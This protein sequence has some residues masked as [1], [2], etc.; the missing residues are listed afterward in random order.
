L[1]DWTCTS[2]QGG[3]GKGTAIY[4][5][6]GRFR[7]GSDTNDWTLIL[8]I[9]SRLD[10]PDDTGHYRYW[11]REAS[12]FESGLLE[13]LSGPLT[14]PRHF[15]TTRVSDDE[16]WIW[17]EMIE[18]DSPHWPLE[19]YSPVAR[20]LGRFN[21]AYLTGE[22]PPEAPWLSTGWLRGMVETGMGGLDVL[23]DAIE[24]PMVR[25]AYPRDVF[26]GLERLWEERDLFLD[27]ID[28]LPQTFCHRDAN[29]RN[30]FYND[31]EKGSSRT[32]A[33]D[34]A[35]TGTGAIGEEIVGLAGSSIMFGAVGPEKFEELDHLVFENYVAGLRDVGWEGD[36]SVP[37]LGY[38]A[39]CP[40]HYNFKAVGA[41]VNF[42]LNEEGHESSLKGLERMTGRPLSILQICD[43]FSVATR[44]TLTLAEEARTLIRT[45]EG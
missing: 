20:H 2:L 36:E 11:K 43:E 37:R 22:N 38:S 19:R 21:G 45:L 31:E 17:M 40:V 28:R 9:L 32:V 25:R 34:W 23:R 18:N 4:R 39:A 33:I 8:K 27:A 1:D 15:G 10:R 14:A 5:V 26:E 13:E 30:L 7:V 3:Y 29:W 24:K 44:Y 16:H 12:I 41:M 42:L 35:E 6:S